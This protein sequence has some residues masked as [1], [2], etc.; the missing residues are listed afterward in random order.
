MRSIKSFGVKPWASTKSEP[1]DFT[2]VDGGTA[3]LF[4]RWALANDIRH[5]GATDETTRLCQR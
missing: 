3:F 1:Y 5:Q 2:L 4:L